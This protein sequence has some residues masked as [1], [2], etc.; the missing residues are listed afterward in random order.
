MLT[1]YFVN[2]RRK[3]KNFT[4]SYNKPKVEA[5]QTNKKKQSVDSKEVGEKGQRTDKMNRKQLEDDEFK[6]NLII[7][8]STTYIKVQRLSPNCRLSTRNPLQI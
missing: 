5:K 7:T 4:K 1:I 3:L 6:S 8:L 2:P